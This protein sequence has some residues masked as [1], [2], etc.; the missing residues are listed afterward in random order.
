MNRTSNGEAYSS[1]CFK[2][3]N[4]SV[5]VTDDFMEAVA[6][7]DKWTTTWVSDKAR[8]EAPTYDAKET[9]Q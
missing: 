6:N 2:N 9:A 7:G 5:R 4:L 8:G 1:V 3:A